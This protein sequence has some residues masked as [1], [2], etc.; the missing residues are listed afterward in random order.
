[1]IV[2][3]GAIGKGRA[4]V[5][6]ACHRNCR[7]FWRITA[8]AKTDEG[9]TM[10]R[11]DKPANSGGSIMYRFLYGLVAAG[12]FVVAASTSASAQ[13]LP[14]VGSPIPLP[15]PSFWISDRG[16]QLKI[17][18]SDDKPFMGEVDQHFKAVLNSPHAPPGCQYQTFEGEAGGEFFFPQIAFGVQW[19]NWTQDC[20]SQTIWEGVLV[21]H[22]RLW[23]SWSTTTLKADG[24]FGRTKAS[25]N[26][27]FRLQP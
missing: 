7:R 15:V 14:H 1:M 11:R 24:S 2:D 13:K 17:Y 19:K 27:T 4:D 8:C 12:L 6:Q 23:T 26:E 16:A 10:T 22:N 3:T 20:H 21:N 5:T 9:T 18:A 25:G